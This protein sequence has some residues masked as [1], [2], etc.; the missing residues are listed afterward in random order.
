MTGEDIYIVIYGQR[1][2]M[3]KP[4]KT[5]SIHLISSPTLP[6][7][8]SVNSL[9][10]LANYVRMRRFDVN[11]LLAGTGIH[12]R[13][14]DNPDIF[15]TP[16]QEL[17]VMRKIIT[18]VPESKIGLIIG[19]HYHIGVQGKL[20]AAAIFSDTGLEAVTMFFK[21]IALTLTYFQYE[22]TVKDSLASLRIKE[23]I[24]LKD[25][26][27]F[28][29]EREFVSIYRIISDV[30][31]API[32]LKEIRFTYPKPAYAS[33]YEDV[34]HCPVKFNA[35]EHMIL[36]DSKLLSMPLPMSNPIAKKTYEQECKSECQ[37]LKVKETMTDQ[38]RQE[39]LFKKETF[40]S[41]TQLSRHMNISPR[42]L[43]RRL[44][45]EKTSYKSL[46]EDIRKNKAIDL[47]QT[48]TQSTQQIAAELG[49]S[50]LSNFYRA[51]KRWTGRN[52]GFYRKESAV[53]SKIVAASPDI[54]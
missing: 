22:L 42:T 32:P 8:R 30:L 4:S 41:F 35:R 48:T 37:R 39:I 51:F 46:V 10:I 53:S 18:L 14:L 50:D 21:Y 54:S 9:A 25:L 34:F 52:P 47:L 2:P 45:G 26:R 31:K 29:C 17:A 12:R 43:R 24:D 19:L 38:V 28:V 20:G 7:F 40:P 49:Y 13:D 44:I 11:V 23:L 6:Y 33:S 3:N 1:E 5:D 36:F 16:E 15:I 27:V